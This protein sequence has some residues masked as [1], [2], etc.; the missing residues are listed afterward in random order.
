M[1]TNLLEKLHVFN[2]S[3]VMSQIITLLL[4]KAVLQE[5]YDDQKQ[6]CYATVMSVSIYYNCSVFVNEAFMCKVR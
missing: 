3:D 2:K 4:L 1:Y 5:V 6:V